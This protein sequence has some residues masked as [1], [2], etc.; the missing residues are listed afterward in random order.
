MT[1]AIPVSTAPTPSQPVQPVPPN[2]MKSHRKEGS[3]TVFRGAVQKV[4]AATIDWT[5]ERSDEWIKKYGHK[6]KTV[7][8]TENHGLVDRLKE[9]TGED[10]DEV[11]PFFSSYPSSRVLGRQEYR[12]KRFCAGSTPPL[13]ALVSEGEE[14][15]LSDPDQGPSAWV[16]D[17]NWYPEELQHV[18]AS[19]EPYERVLDSKELFTILEKKRFS[20]EENDQEVG[21]P[22]RIYVNKPDGNSIFAILKTTPPSQVPGYQELLANYITGDPSP[23]IRSREIFWWGANCF[24]F[25]FNLP[26]FVTSSQAHGDDRTLFNGKRPLR[27]RYDLSFLNLGVDEQEYFNEN[28]FAQESLFLV[29]GVCSIVVT[30]RSDKYWTA[31]CFNDDLTKDEDEPRLSPEDEVQHI[32]GETDPI[33]IK[34]ENAAVLPRAYALAALATTLMKIADYHRDIQA[35]LRI[36]LNHHTPT[37]WHSFPDSLSNDQMNDWRKKYFD[38][39][40]LVIDCNIRLIEKLERFLSRD[41]LMTDAGLPQH[42]LW[43]SVIREERAIQSLIEIRDSLDQLSDVNSELTRFLKVCLEERREVRMTEIHY[44]LVDFF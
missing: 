28:G 22:R 17:R 13:D 36:S 7:A 38:V 5:T 42:P 15:G 12:V 26:F 1:R 11:S 29:E 34:M 40:N 24:L 30:G 27:R 16:S 43:Q 31:A 33:I 4:K 14:N 35:E 10:F 25:S 41:L 21:P 2:C 32:D 44:D 39:L 23:V 18:E 3:F 37:P 8:S 20:E 6:N 19:K 9:G